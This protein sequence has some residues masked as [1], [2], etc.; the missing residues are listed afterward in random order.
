[1]IL[2]D[3]GAD[4]IKV[5]DP[6]SGDYERQIG[7]PI[8]SMAYRF[9]LLNRN[10]RSLAIDLKKR[11]GREVFSKILEKSDSLVESFRPGTMNRLGLDYESTKG[12]NPALVYCS[13]SSFG[14]TGPYRDKVAHDL[15][16]L[17]SSG[18]LHMTGSPEG[19]LAIPGVPF[20]DIV[21]AL[22]GAIAILAAILLKRNTGKGQ[23]LDISMFDSALSLLIDLARYVWKEDREPQRGKERLCGGLANYNIYETK[24]HRSLSVAAL[25][26]KYKRALFQ[27]LGMKDSPD[28]ENEVTTS[29][30]ID[31]R[32]Q[33]TKKEMRKTF[34]QRKLDE[35]NEI[36]GAA[37]YFY[38]PVRT[39]SEALSDP[40]ALHREM[41]FETS[42][43]LCGSH[44]SLGSPLK[45]SGTPP[46]L[47]RIPAPSLGQH[48]V[49]ILQEIGL[50]TE[51][52]EEM[53]RNGIISSPL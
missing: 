16:I 13:L 15:N 37:N 32:E 40:Q 4:V 7:P 36:L 22:Y 38:W 45:L 52:I 23:H 49:S 44:R 48:S 10:K 9:L 28:N 21:T 30:V 34:S 53:K 46:D 25:E 8:G 5:E 2:A 41:I 43:P 11:R 3:L 39:V 6:I 20:I 14:H 29:R 50:E 27:V 18:I 31:H 12:I 47:T 17:A 51:E 1:M 19:P 26:T 35:W 24:D 33:E 42:H